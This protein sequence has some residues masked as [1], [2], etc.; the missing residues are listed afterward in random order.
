MVAGVSAGVHPTDGNGAGVGHFS[1]HGADPP[2]K[3]ALIGNHRGL[4]MVNVKEECK[5]AD[6]G[7]EY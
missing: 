5:E 6:K 1:C 7:Y 4:K 3:I 2:K